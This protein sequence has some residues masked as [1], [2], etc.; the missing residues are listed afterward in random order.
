MD[1]CGAL[2]YSYE[3][4]CD[5]YTK[6]FSYDFEPQKGQQCAYLF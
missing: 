2:K 5:H 6:R 4:F 1:F 3:L